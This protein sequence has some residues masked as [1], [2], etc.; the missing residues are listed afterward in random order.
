MSHVDEVARYYAD[1]APVYDETAGYTDP[2]AEQLREPIKARYRKLFAGRDVLEVAC[3]TGYWTEVVGETAR[4]VTGVDI[5]GSLLSIAQ[6]RCRRLPNIRF[7]TA[8]AYTL[9]G[10]ATGFTA[11]LGVWWWSHM[12]KDHVSTF[13]TALHSRLVPGAVVMFVDQLPYAGHIRSQDSDGNTLERRPLPDGRAVDI[14]KN[15]PT[16]AELRGALRGIA[17][18]VQYVARPDEKSWTVVYNTSR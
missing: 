7:Q 10:V 3:G 2:V 12:P 8:D 18:D 4:A 9:E 6:G 13:L 1:R 14:I 5:N 15:F 17:E 16:E 11:A